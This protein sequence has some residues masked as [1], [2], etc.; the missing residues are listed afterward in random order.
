MEMNV[1][2]DNL[3]TAIK[4]DYANYQDASSMQSERTKETRAQMREEFFNS[5]KYSVGQKYIKVIKDRSV[6]GFVVNTTEDKKFR[7]GDILKAAGYST[8]A[9]NSARGNV[10]ED[11]DVRWTGPNYLR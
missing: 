11:Y 4:T 3:L 5:L 6:W 2:I 7:Y 9:R 10:F 8:P 1:A